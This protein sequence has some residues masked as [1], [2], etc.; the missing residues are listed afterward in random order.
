MTRVLISLLMTLLVSAAAASPARKV[1]P[2]EK[3]VTIKVLANQETFI[4]GVKIGFW[5]LGI[6]LNKRLWRSFVGNS[7]MPASILVVYEGEVTDEWKTATLKGVREGQQRTLVMLSLFKYKKKFEDI[8]SP[9]KEKIK[10]QFP[11]LFQENYH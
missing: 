11:V 2:I 1:L 10:R 6:E 9:K 4:D 5:E 8:S 7:K 3:T